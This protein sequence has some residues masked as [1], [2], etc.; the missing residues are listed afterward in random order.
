[1]TSRDETAFS[2][3]RETGAPAASGQTLAVANEAMVALGNDEIDEAEYNRRVADEP[4]AE[5]IV[6]ESDAEPPTEPELPAVPDEPE[7][8]PAESDAPA[9]PSGPQEDPPPAA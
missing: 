3:N 7:A 2:L 8:P 4:A 9:A 5:N 6:A 1:V